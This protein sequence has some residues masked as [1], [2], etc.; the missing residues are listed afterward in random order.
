MLKITIEGT[1]GSGKTRVSRFLCEVGVLYP[2]RLF[3]GED[4]LWMSSGQLPQYKRRD[5]NFFT[6]SR[7]KKASVIIIEQE[8]EYRVKKHSKIRLTQKRA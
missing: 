7:R 2:H 1:Q 8:G 6:P 3:C 4:V 5:Q